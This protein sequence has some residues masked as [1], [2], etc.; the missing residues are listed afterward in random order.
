MARVASTADRSRW[1]GPSPGEVDGVARGERGRLPGVEQRLL[2][3]ELQR[4]AR[5]LVADRRQHAAGRRHRQ[6]GGDVVARGPDS[7]KALIVSQ[8]PGFCADTKAR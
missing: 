8:A 4:L 6:L 2:A 7:P 5:A 3:P 1:T